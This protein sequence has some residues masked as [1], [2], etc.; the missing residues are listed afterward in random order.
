LKDKLEILHRKDKIDIIV[1]SGDLTSIGA[2]EEFDHL[3]NEFLPILED[4]FLKGA[5]VV[6][7]N[8]WIVVPGNH[9]VEWEK[10]DARFNNFI[11]FCQENGFQEY[12]LNNP[13]SIYSRFVCRDKLTGNTIG[14][15]ALNSCLDIYGE[16]SPNISN[17]SN[18]YF[19]S[20][21][22]DWDFAFRDM[23]KLMVTHHTLHS[24]KKDRFNNALNKLSD[25]N[26]LL[27]LA[28]DIHKSESRADVISN[29]RCIPAGTVLA[30]KTERQVGIDEVSRQFNL[31]NLN[32]HDG[33]VNWSTY[34]FEGN[35]REIKNESFYLEHP[36]FSQRIE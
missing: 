17:I 18:S 34:I 31:V 26:V 2:K 4:V 27:D 14:I 30:K 23:P 36:S 13:E 29:I 6:P 9:D 10:E 35:W 19:S 28:G 12:E 3:M 16:K 33:L 32:L 21:S 8:R 15:I 1:I 11:Q 25:N 24:I 22:K 20:F 5:H 7:K